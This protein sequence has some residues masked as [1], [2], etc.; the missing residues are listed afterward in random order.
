MPYGVGV[1][2]D[3]KIKGI[4]SGYQPKLLCE[5][6]VLEEMDNNSPLF[7]NWCMLDTKLMLRP[8]SDLGNEIEYNG[9]KII[10]L[11]IF[12]DA[13]GV[14]I[15]YDNGNKKIIFDNTVLMDAQNIPYLHLL[16][17]F[18]LHFDIFNLIEQGLAVAI[19]TK[20]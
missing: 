19:E 12:E 13:C 14:P 11:E 6:I 9:K 7:K 15:D 17:L 1:I 3:N 8:L 18:E 16:I 2:F 5:L 20:K 4:L 10:P